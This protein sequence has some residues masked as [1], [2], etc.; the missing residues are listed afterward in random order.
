MNRGEVKQRRPPKQSFLYN[1]PAPLLLLLLHSRLLQSTGKASDAL[2]ESHN[3]SDWLLSVKL[4]LPKI[5]AFLCT[6]VNTE[7]RLPINQLYVCQCLYKCTYW[8]VF[9]NQSETFDKTLRPSK[10]SNCGRYGVR[11]GTAGGTDMSC[12]PPTPRVN[13]WDPRVTP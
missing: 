9:P 12:V 7:I 10:E 13:P 6:L 3:W 4:N 8:K 5:F 2:V 1:D 11:L